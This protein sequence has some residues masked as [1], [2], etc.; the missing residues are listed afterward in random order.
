MGSQ[1][2][3]AWILRFPSSLIKSRASKMIFLSAT[4][5]H[6]KFMMSEKF[7]LAMK[8]I[9]GALIDLISLPLSQMFPSILPLPVKRLMLLILNF[10]CF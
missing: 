1:V 4:V 9:F 2:P 5:T 8:E 6:L 3:A 10:S 7:P